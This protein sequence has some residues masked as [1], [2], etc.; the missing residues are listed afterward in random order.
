MRKFFIFTAGLIVLLTLTWLTA[1]AQMNTVVSITGSV[2]NSV[3]KDPIRVGYKLVDE[4]D[5]VVRR[6]KTNPAQ[7]GY[8]FITGLAPGGKYKLVFDGDDNYF[9][10]EFAVEIPNTNKYEEFSKDFLISPK[11][12]GME[13]PQRVPVFELNKSKLRGGADLFLEDIFQT[14]A[15]NPALKFTIVAYPDNNSNEGTNETLTQSR[16]QAL[17]EYFVAKKIDASRIEIKA[18]K[19]TD[20]KNPP[21]TEKRAKGKRYI[22]SIYYLVNEF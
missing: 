7:N 14:L 2:F 17:K 20:P 16:C 9:K 3:T 18:N 4:S 8:Y 10:A 13:L 21:P 1:S 6:G 15:D 11:S 5:K 22:G 12:K 19:S